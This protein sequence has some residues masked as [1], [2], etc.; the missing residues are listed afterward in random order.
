M[1]PLDDGQRTGL[2]DSDHEY[3][4]RWSFFVLQMSAQGTDFGEKASVQ[5]TAS[6]YADI[7]RDLS[8]CKAATGDLAPMRTR[9]NSHPRQVCRMQLHF[10]PLRIRREFAPHSSSSAEKQSSAKC[11]LICIPEV[12]RGDNLF[13]P[14]PVTVEFRVIKLVAEK[15]GNHLIFVNSLSFQDRRNSGLEPRL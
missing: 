2:V 8:Q 12:R 3:R 6:A 13:Q 15:T 5:S 7:F 14:L 10:P 1:V 4:S 9:K 11:V